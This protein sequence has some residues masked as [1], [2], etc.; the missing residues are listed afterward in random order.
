MGALITGALLLG[1]CIRAS[2]VAACE[3]SWA[4]SHPRLL[5]CQLKP[6]QLNNSR[7]STKPS[8]TMTVVLP[9]LQGPQIQPN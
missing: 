1:V 3:P 8:S 2:D 5:P 4:S 9:A 6:S 7:G